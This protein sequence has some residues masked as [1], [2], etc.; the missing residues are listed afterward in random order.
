MSGITR[1]E[2]VG[3]LTAHG[4]VLDSL[5]EHD[6]TLFHQFPWLVETTTGP[7]RVTENRPRIPLSFTILAHVTV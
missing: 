7:A 2:I 3:A 1:R 4:L 6:W 5:I